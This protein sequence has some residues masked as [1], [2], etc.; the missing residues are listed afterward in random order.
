MDLPWRASNGNVDPLVSGRKRYGKRFLLSLRHGKLSMEFP[1]A[2]LGLEILNRT[3]EK[4]ACS[5][6]PSKASFSTRV[7][8]I[9]QKERPTGLFSYASLVSSG[10]RRPSKTSVETHSPN[11][12]LPSTAGKKTHLSGCLFSIFLP[13]FV[14]QRYLFHQTP[15]TGRETRKRSSSCFQR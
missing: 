4:V 5:T 1:S 12:Q 13:V 9:K 3:G 15:T 8:A 10:A 6:R 11:E 2:L 7:P 14:L